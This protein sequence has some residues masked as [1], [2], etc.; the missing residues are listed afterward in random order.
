VT[1]SSKDKRI[2]TRRVIAAY[3]RA[4]SADDREAQISDA[5][6]ALYAIAEDASRVDRE[7]QAIAALG[8]CP[9]CADAYCVL[10]A[11]AQTH[12][13]ARDLFALGVAAAEL[14]LG[15]ENMARYRGRFWFYLDSRPYLRARFGLALRLVALGDDA[16][17]ISH[18]QAMLELNPGDNQGARYPLLA[19]LLRKGDDDGVATLLEAIGEEGSLAWVYTRALMAFRRHGGD[20]PEVAELGRGA[21]AANPYVPKLLAS[22]LHLSRPHLHSAM[23]GPEDAASF[24]LHY[25]DAWRATPGAASWIVELAGVEWWPARGKPSKPRP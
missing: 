20:H 21:L 12:A 17:A 2:P 24:V 11:E 14:A 9:L 8:I 7:A 15:P 6:A 16:G 25:G 1:N 3:H 5:Q 13:R 4:S 10:A 19:A 18:F 22:G 23:G